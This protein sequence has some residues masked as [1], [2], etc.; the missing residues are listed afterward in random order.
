MIKH[1]GINK[2]AIRL[3]SFYNEEIGQDVKFK[4]DPLYRPEHNMN[5][6]A[7]IEALPEKVDKH[8]VD[9]INEVR[10][11]GCTHIHFDYKAISKDEYIMDDD[12][13]IYFIP[14]ELVYCATYQTDKPNAFHDIPPNRGALIEHSINKRNGNESYTYCVPNNGI[15]LCK[16]FYGFGYE[17]EVVD[18]FEAIVKKENGIVVDINPDPDD[19]IAQ[20]AAVGYFPPNYFEQ[21][22]NQ[23][24]LVFRATHTN[25]EYDVHGVKLYVMRIELV[26]GVIDTQAFD[27]KGKKRFVRQNHVYMGDKLREGG[28]IMDDIRA[29]QG[30]VK[31]YYS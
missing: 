29:N 23:G 2:I 19:R 22:I 15:I 6:S 28:A 9:F 13:R 14:I 7:Q 1:A 21:D 11:T 27:Y 25:Y 3:D 17:T 26:W 31:V 4:I 30:K 24:D 20:V 8:F 5:T 10:D 12:H 18:G 16:P